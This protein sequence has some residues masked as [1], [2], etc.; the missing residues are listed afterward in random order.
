MIDNILQE[1]AQEGL[2]LGG[3]K[4]AAGVR[5]AN[6]RPGLKLVRAATPPLRQPPTDHHHL[7]PAKAENTVSVDPGCAD[8]YCWNA[9]SI[10]T[11]LGQTSGQSKPDKIARVNLVFSRTA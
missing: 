7:P 2:C 1:L 11:G 10:A 9:R 3:G 5:A 4:G 6:A 8:Q